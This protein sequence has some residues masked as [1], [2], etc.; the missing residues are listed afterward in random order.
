V[1]GQWFSL[2]TP[3][4]SIN[5]TNCHDITEILLKVVLNTIALSSCMYMYVFLTEVFNQDVLEQHF[6]HHRGRCES[7]TN[8]TL[9]DM[10]N[11]MTHLRVIGS[12]AVSGASGNSASSIAV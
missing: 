9:S 5:K 11:N 10:D 7:N 1:T 2:V 4:S 12:Q 3:V 8:P 6:G